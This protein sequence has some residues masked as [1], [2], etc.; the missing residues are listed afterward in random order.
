VAW[1]DEDV[2]SAR[3]ARGVQKGEAIRGKRLV[4]AVGEPQQDETLT[5]A[6]TTVAGSP[7]ADLR[8]KEDSVRPLP[9]HAAALTSRAPGPMVTNR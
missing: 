5:F 8:K 4:E 9:R 2:R 7:R 3:R 1:R 6:I